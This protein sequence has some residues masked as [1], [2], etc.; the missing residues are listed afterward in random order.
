MLYH[1]L[2][3]ILNVNT[4]L[5]RR[6]LHLATVERV[7]GDPDQSPR[8]GFCTLPLGGDEGGLY[9]RRLSFAEVHHDAA[10][11]DGSGVQL[12]VRTEGID[13]HRAVRPVEGI[14]TAEV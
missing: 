12:E 14:A 13:G 9:Y 10:G 3:S 2:M 7:V 5:R 6:A 8:G 1:D 11:L 4:L